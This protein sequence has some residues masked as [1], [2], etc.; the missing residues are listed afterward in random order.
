MAVATLALV[1]FNVCTST[2][3]ASPGMADSDPGCQVS[4][5]TRLLWTM[6]VLAAAAGVFVVMRASWYAVAGLAAGN[7]V[8]LWIDMEGPVLI[9]RGTHGVHVADIPVLISF[10]AI[11]VAVVRLVTQRRRRLGK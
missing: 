11:V 8:W 7:L 2:L 6:V 1:A 4:E 3:A 10:A 5:V 9:S